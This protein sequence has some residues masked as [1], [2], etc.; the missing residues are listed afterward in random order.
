MRATK[1][2]EL[3]RSRKHGA[4]F[5]QWCD[6]CASVTCHMKS[7]C[8]ANV[9]IHMTNRRHSNMNLVISGFESA[10]LRRGQ[11]SKRKKH[12]GKRNPRGANRTLPELWFVNTWTA[13]HNRVCTISSELHARCAA[14]GRERENPGRDVRQRLPNDG[15]AA[16]LFMHI[17]KISVKQ[18][19]TATHAKTSHPACT[20]STSPRNLTTKT[21]F[22]FGQP[23]FGSACRIESRSC[24]F[25]L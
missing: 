14:N 10:R 20:A 22:V 23:K 17:E 25:V 8:H 7:S 6:A 15:A 11:L 3:T 16:A 24:Q 19:S 5:I 1:L 12:E 21:F 13:R 4:N 18:R 9:P 2:L